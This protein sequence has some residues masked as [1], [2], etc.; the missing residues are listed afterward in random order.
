MDIEKVLKVFAEDAS[1]NVVY[2]VSDTNEEVCEDADDVYKVDVRKMY[3]EYQQRIKDIIF[4]DGVDFE[5]SKFCIEVIINEDV[6]S[7][8]EHTLYDSRE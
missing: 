7:V 6:V 1:F 8:A 2:F 4:K 3:K 5:Y